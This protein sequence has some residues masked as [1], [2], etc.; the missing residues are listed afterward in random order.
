MNLIKGRRWKLDSMFKGSVIT[1]FGGTGTI[2]SEIVDQ[3][4]CFQVDSIRI[5]SNDENSLFESK[6]KWENNP[7][8]RWILGD[9]RDKRKVLMACQGVNYVFNC[10]AIKHVDISEYNPMEAVD[11]NIQGLENIIQ[12]CMVIGIERLLHISTDKAVEPTS[13]MGATKLIAERLCMIREGAKG[14]NLTKIG[15]VR[16]GNVYDSRGSVI[17]IVRKKLREKKEITVSDWNVRRYFMSI[18]DA[19][20]FIIN[21]MQLFKGGEIHIPKLESK[22]L[23][24]V[25]QDLMIEEGINPSTVKS[26]KT[27]LKRGEKLEERLYCDADGDRTVAEGRII[28]TG[29]YG[30]KKF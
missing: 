27:G 30:G 13:V 29:T 23:T 5:F 18:I 17:Q 3:L 12:T 19:G 26:R 8:L 22:Y 16:L 20:S 4:L 21:T 7:R 2:G 10:A 6:Q 11:V 28:L 24:T 1:V 25:L 14:Y 15:V 9:V